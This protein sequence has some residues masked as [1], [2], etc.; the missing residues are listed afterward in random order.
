VAVAYLAAREAAAEGPFLAE[1]RELIDS[2]ADMLG[3]HLDRRLADEALLATQQSLTAQVEE[4]T[5]DLRRLA[6]QLTLT[7]AR[8]RREIASQLHDHV[9]QA[10]AHM[11]QHVRALQGNAVFSGNAEDIQEIL[12]LLDLTI[13]Y[14]RDLTA[15][16]SPPVLYALGLEPALDWLAEQMLLKQG[17]RVHLSSTGTVRPLPEAHQVILYQA[18]RELLANSAQHSGAAEA[19]LGIEWTDWGVGIDVSDAGRGFDA[20]QPLSHRAADGFG[21]FSVRE[22]LR[23]LGGS[24]TVTSAPGAGCTV[25]LRVPV[26]DWDVT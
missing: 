14:T 4:R 16:I 7:E 12:R 5:A 8:Q 6:S 21:L 25:A 11:K 3:A 22:R 20:S 18:A 9:G 10:L 15:Q 17:F 19:C 24:A 26:P 13:R 23:D 2:L 1:E